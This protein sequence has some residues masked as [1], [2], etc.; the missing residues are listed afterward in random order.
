MAWN[1]RKLSEVRIVEKNVPVPLHWLVNGY[2]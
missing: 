2:L 1:G